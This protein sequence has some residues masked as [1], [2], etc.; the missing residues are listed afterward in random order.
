MEPAPPRNPCLISLFPNRVE[1]CHGTLGYRRPVSSSL[2]RGP[3]SGVRLPRTWRSPAR[4]F[5][6]YLVFKFNLSSPPLDS[7]P[8]MKLPPLLKFFPS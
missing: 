6:R 8:I 5:L 3:A 1:Q 2:G 4:Q 7:P